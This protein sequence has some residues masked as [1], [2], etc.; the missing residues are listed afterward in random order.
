MMILFRPMIAFVGTT[1]V[2]YAT[3][4]L[5]LDGDR[6][7]KLDIRLPLSKPPKPVKLD[8]RT[9]A[10]ARVSAYAWAG[11]CWIRVGSAKADESGHVTLEACDAPRYRVVVGKK[12]TEVERKGDRVVINVE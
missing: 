6:D 11:S 3:G 8:I 12:K 10:N 4:F 9:E 2:E 7:E 1:R 5:W